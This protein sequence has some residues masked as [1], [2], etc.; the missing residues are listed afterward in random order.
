MTAPVDVVGQRFGR[1]LV[2][3][4]SEKRTKAMKQMVLCKCDCGT[5]REVVVGN[6]RSGLSTSCGCWKDEKTSARRKKHGFSQSTM[7]GRYKEMIKRCYIPDHP[8]YKNYGGRGI[9][10]CERWLESIEN[11]VEDMNFP[12]FEKAQI[13]RINNDLGYSKENCRWATPQQNSLNKRKIRKS[14]VNA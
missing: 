2:I 11:Y 3:E 5:E 13:D 7:Y 8:E 9:K 10:V 1:Y 6:L 12:P 14:A 4:K